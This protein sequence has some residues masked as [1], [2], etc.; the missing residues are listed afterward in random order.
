MFPDQR[1]IQVCNKLLD[2][3]TFV[4]HFTVQLKRLNIIRMILLSMWILLRNEYLF[5]GR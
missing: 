5:G 3:K 1:L 2:F 4:Y